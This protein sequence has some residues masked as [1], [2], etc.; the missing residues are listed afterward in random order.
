MTPLTN[1]WDPISDAAPID[2]P[3]GQSRNS[4]DAFTA[5]I[6]TNGSK[7]T[8]LS[9]V[10]EMMLEAKPPRYRRPEDRPLRAKSR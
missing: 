5:P 1:R 2:V 8:V 4:P 6:N 9:S 10:R 3:A 7:M